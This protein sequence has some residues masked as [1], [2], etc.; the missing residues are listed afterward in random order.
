MKKLIIITMALVLSGVLLWNSG[1]RKITSE[2]MVML[3]PMWISP[4]LKER[5][6]VYHSEKTIKDTIT[7][8]EKSSLFLSNQ[9]EIPGT[10]II[11][12]NLSTNTNV[13]VV[14]VNY[15]F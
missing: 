10:S 4:V 14:N 1:D 7:G 3:D 8:S 9:K 12:R 13:K 11:R 6:I 5:M 15:N 2:E